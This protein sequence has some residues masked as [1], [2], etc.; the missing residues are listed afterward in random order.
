LRAASTAAITASGAESNTETVE[1]PS[2]I[3]P[4]NRP[5]WVAMESAINSSWRTRASAIAVGSVSHMAV[6]PSMSDM[7]KVTTP[8]GSAAAQ[9]ARSRSISSPGV[10]GRRP[11]S[12][13]IPIRMAASSWSACV[14]SIPFHAGSVPAGAEPVSS[15]N[16]VAASA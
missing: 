5:P 13:A 4:M 14:G 16:A 3:D 11:G 12:V 8:V 7:Q 6:E 10:A 9:P 2:P 1:S 15:A